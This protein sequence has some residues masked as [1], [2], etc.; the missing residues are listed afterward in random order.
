MLQQAQAQ[1]G[2]GLFRGGPPR[3]RHADVWLCGLLRR[4][5]WD[6]RQAGGRRQG[7]SVSVQARCCVASLV[8]ECQ[9]PTRIP[10]SP[11][12]PPAP[13]GTPRRRAVQQTL[14]TRSRLASAPRSGRRAYWQENAVAMSGQHRVA[15]LAASVMRQ[16][17]GHTVGQR[18]AFGT[19]HPCSCSPSAS[20]PAAAFRQRTS[21]SA[22]GFRSSVGAWSADESENL[23]ESGIVRGAQ[24]CG[25]AW[26]QACSPLAAKAAACRRV[27]WSTN[28]LRPCRAAAQF[29]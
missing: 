9:M 12:A 6:D 18:S 5:C 7:L 10:P 13:P 25:Q 24:V 27:A 8:T 22:R 15:R 4:L 19:P 2:C 23:F 11:A 3:A 17:A 20:L 16:L 14:S 21:T 28:W 26:G 1:W 29:P